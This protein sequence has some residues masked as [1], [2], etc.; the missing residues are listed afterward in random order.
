MS[1]IPRTRFRRQVRNFALIWGGITF[2]MGV[3]TFIA[4]YA[5]YG[6][7]TGSGDTLRNIA[8][9]TGTLAVQQAAV[10]P[11]SAPLPT[12]LPPTVTPQVAAAAQATQQTSTPASTATRLPVDIKR[13]QL[14]VQV[15]L[16]LD[17]MD[18][19]TDVAANQLSVK[20]VKYQ[21][22]WADV[23]K[24]KGDYDWLSGPD[25][26]LP[27]AAAKNL[28][29]MVSIVTA[30]DWARESGADLSKNGPPANSQDYA[31]FVVALLRRYPGKI[32]AVEV[33][34]EENLDRE[35]KSTKGLS[36]ASYIDLLHTAYQAI[37]AVDPGVIV[38][39]GALSPTG[40]NDG[41]GAYDDFVYM[42]A[43]L[44]AGL[45]N[46]T[47][48]VGAHHNGYNVSPEFSYDTIPND[49]SAIFRGPFDNPHHSWSF[50]ST[51][52]TYAAKIA[53]APNNSGQKLCVTEFGWP[54]AEG[55]SGVPDG[56]EFAK[57]N[58][59]QEQRDY[60]VKAL[61]Y[62]KS[63]NFVWLAFLWNL[64]YGPQAGWAADNDNV[65]YSIIGPNFAFRPVF[66][67]VRDWNRAYE[68][69]QPN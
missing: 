67:G 35:W 44:A 59:L 47:D 46:Y 6:S 14:G 40:V 24:Q 51:L 56:F 69:T 57:D 18:Q 7:L 36:A 65:P 31:D 34:N 62:M 15:Q 41:V 12:L 1:S 25:T 64:N 17:H 26:F 45:L 27:S 28:K 11:T 38:I 4:I 43:M 9:P 16:S 39:S 49:P 68:A 22:R 63:S 42:D 33:W 55:L 20:W 58:T 61:D 37:K 19:W 50:R 52:Q 5:A 66:D 30:P 54:S 32:H 29:V 23:E 60:T 10:A 53:Q 2:I 8:I 13:F 3:T 21:I 48:C